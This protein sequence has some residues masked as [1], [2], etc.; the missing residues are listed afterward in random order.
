M[1]EVMS[2]GVVVFVYSGPL[3]SG[4]ITQPNTGWAVHYVCI[5]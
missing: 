2:S 5:R 1:Y 3:P 4:A